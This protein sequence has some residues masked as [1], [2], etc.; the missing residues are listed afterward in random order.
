MP[1]ERCVTPGAVLRLAALSFFLFVPA[2]AWAGSASGSY[3]PTSHLDPV[4]AAA[5]YLSPAG[6]DSNPGTYEQPWLTLGKAAASVSAG[7]TVVLEPGTY[8]AR[9]KTTTF[10]RVGTASAPITFRGDPSGPLPTILGYVKITGSYQRFSYLLFDG[11]TGQV[12][13][14]SSANPGG[15]QV[16][17]SV[18]GPAVNGIEISDCEVRYSHWHAGIF[19]STANDVRITGNY[20]HDNGDFSDPGQANTSHGIYFSQGSGLIA[21]NVLEHNVARGVQLYSKPHDVTVANNTI[22]NNG[23]TGIQFASATANSIAVNN[24]VA[25]NSS[26][27]IRSSSLSRTGN[28]VQRNLVWGNGGHDLDPAA[29]LTL[30]D[31]LQLDPGFGPAD[32]YRPPAGSPAIDQAVP[33][34]APGIDFDGLTRPLGAGPDIGAFEVG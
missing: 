21:N 34:Y 6:S 3:S 30:I 27:G 17:V 12:T 23:K 32:D 11:P 5:Y 15:E 7:D 26:Y 19:L 24:L 22:V 1:I 31:N 14:P 16:E 9:G 18:Y 13:K 20:I 10:R 2:L 8:G 28:V 33:S 29:G 25:Y 4:P